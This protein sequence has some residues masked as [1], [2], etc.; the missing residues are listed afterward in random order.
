MNSY[1]YY[2]QL[3]K[4]SRE[5]MNKVQSRLVSQVSRVLESWLQQASLYKI[6]CLFPDHEK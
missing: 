5:N 1:S 4:S 3:V 2:I 6:P